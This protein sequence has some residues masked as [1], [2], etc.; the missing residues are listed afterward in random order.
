MREPWRRKIKA[1]SFDGKAPFDCDPVAPLVA[2]ADV[3]TRA[4]RRHILFIFVIP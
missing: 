3:N 4:I 2:H 1:F